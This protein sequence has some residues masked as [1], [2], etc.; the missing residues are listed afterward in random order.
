MFC[1]VFEN[2]KRSTRVSIGGDVARA[3]MLE[4]CLRYVFRLVF[5]RE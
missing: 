4:K 3:R 5:E 1:Y 2:R